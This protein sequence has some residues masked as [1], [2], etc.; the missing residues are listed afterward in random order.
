MDPRRRFMQ[1][2]LPPLVG[3]FMRK[4]VDLENTPLVVEGFS[5]EL[6][7]PP[8]VLQKKEPGGAEGW[9]S[10]EPLLDNQSHILS[11]AHPMLL[12]H[13]SVTAGCSHNGAKARFV[14]LT[15]S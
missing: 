11:P 3:C 8:R 5:E 13:C 10:S 1:P 15:H 14:K 4:G 7:L 9:S 6:Q 2:L 12:P